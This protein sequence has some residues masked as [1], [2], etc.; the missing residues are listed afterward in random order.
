MSDLQAPSH[1]HS[2]SN[3]NTHARTGTCSKCGPVKISKHGK[4]SEGKQLWTCYMAR[5]ECQSGMRQPK[6][7]ISGVDPD[8]SVATCSICGPQVKVFSAGLRRGIPLWRCA[9][10]VKKNALKPKGKISP[11]RHF[12]S[13]IDSDSMTATCSHCGPVS[14]K[15]RRQQYKGVLQYRCSNYRAPKTPDKQIKQRGFNLM[16]NYGITHEEYNQRLT[17][18]NGVCA[19]CGNP[20]TVMQNGKLRPL[21]VDHCHATGRVRGLLCAKC[22]VGLGAFNDDA[23]V[24]IQGVPWIRLHAQGHP[25]LIEQLPEISERITKLVNDELDK[26]IAAAPINSSITLNPSPEPISPSDLGQSTYYVPSDRTDWR[27]PPPIDHASRPQDDKLLGQLAQDILQLHR[28]DPELASGIGVSIA[29][30]SGITRVKFTDD[31]P[32]S[33]EPDLAISTIAA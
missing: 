32:K 11:K 5:I 4:D 22:N 10:V 8:L 1:R 30:V 33:P 14:I 28:P 27:T 2:L 31:T 17:A 7:T 13:G 20:E 19:L 9:S 24:M 23:D 15:S 18:Q 29:N 26:I 12:L 6:H 3:I 21:A 25:A 16:R